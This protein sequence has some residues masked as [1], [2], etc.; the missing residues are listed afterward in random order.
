M[1]CCRDSN[2]RPPRHRYRCEAGGLGLF[3]RA[4]PVPATQAASG[5]LPGTLVTLV[6]LDATSHPHPELHLTGSESFPDIV[7][8]MSDGLAVPFALVAF[9]DLSA[10]CQSVLG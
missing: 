10:G 1:P 7:I 3:L 6:T 8:G 4:R 2:K 9:A 5:P